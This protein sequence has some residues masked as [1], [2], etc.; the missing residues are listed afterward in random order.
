LNVENIENRAES[1]PLVEQIVN[2]KSIS[3][4]ILFMLRTYLT[5]SVPILLVLLSARLVMTPLFLT[6]EY[7][8]PGFPEDEYGF[9]RED[10]LDL[11]PY[12][13]NYLINNADIAYLGD[14]TFPDGTP[15]Y[16]EREL[17]HMEDVQIVTRAAFSFLLIAGLGAIAASFFLWR[18]PATRYA[19]RNGLFNGAILTLSLILAIT[20]AAVGAWDFFFTTFHSLFF[21]SGT[22]RFLYSDTLIRLFPEQ[23][24]FDASLTIGGLTVV[25]ALVILWATWRWGKMAA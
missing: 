1:L 5:I 15:L 6:I 11:A 2:P 10:R 16:N 20:V 24:W 23:F 7:G 22:W 4:P 3:R 25:G 14:L 9:T 8:R 19:L 13:L 12:A 18:N 17:Q 21:E